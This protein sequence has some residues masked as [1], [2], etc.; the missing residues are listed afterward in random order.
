MHH[1]TLIDDKNEVITIPE[2][3]SKT[4][5]FWAFSSNSLCFCLSLIFACF[6][7][8]SIVGKTFSS[9]MLLLKLMKSFQCWYR[10]RNTISYKSTNNQLSICHFFWFFM[11]AHWH[12]EIFFI[13]S[14]VKDCLVPSQSKHFELWNLDFAYK[15]STQYLLSIYHIY[16]F[17]TISK[18]Y[19]WIRFF[20]N[21][22]FALFRY[23]TKYSVFYIIQ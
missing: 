19:F 1:C 8:L 12:K 17:S 23:W 22:N 13:I 9:A 18:Y 16:K 11:K 5:T 21:S 20:G 10:Y 15:I 6:L 4:L 2:P 3:S 7:L 14:L